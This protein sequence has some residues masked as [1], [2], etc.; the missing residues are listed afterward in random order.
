MTRSFLAH[1]PL[2]F[3]EEVVRR[4]ERDQKAISTLALY[5]YSI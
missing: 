5:L 2:N 3:R 4:G 1:K